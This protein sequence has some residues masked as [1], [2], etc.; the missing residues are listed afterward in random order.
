LPFGRQGGESH[1]GVLRAAGGLE[2]TEAA[3]EGLAPVREERPKPAID[4]EGD[5]RFARAGRFVAGDDLRRQRFDLG[6]VAS[7]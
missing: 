6:C 4:E 3:Q 2:L 7:G 5:A 1:A